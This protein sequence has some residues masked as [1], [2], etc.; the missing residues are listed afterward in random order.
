MEV[1]NLVNNYGIIGVISNYQSNLK[2][3]GKV[4]NLNIKNL[5]KALKMVELDESVID[6]NIDSLS[7]S[8]IF[9]LELAT[10]L[11]NEIIIIGNL[12]NTLNY[13]DIEYIKKLLLKLNNDYQKK[14]VVIDNDIKMFFN[15]AK[16]IIVMQNKNIL[17]ETEDFYDDKLY[18]YVKMPKIIE[19]IKYVN[20]SE[21][22]LNNNVD[23]Y[24]LIKDI[25][26]SVS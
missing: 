23:I 15:L 10:K 9:K 4:S 20:K 18:E 1:K 19:F 24:E 11:N 12:S 17:Y 5:N 14:I 2:M 25:Y 21:K 3:E 8:D 7:L 26:R 16:K 22:K 6:K 13:K